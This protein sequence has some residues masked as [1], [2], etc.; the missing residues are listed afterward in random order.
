[1]KTKIIVTLGPATNTEEALRHIK[2]RGGDFVRV[3]MSHSSLSDQE[4]FMDLAR[5][6]GIPFILDTEGSQVRNGKMK[7]GLVSVAEGSEVKIYK[8]DI[9]GDATRL[10]FHPPEIFS[11]LA[12][13]DLVYIDFDAAILRISD[14]SSREEGFIVAQVISAG[15]IG[16]NKGVVMDPLHK[17]KY[18]LP[19]LSEKDLTAITMALG[20]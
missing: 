12:E 6:V 3:N 20:G 10:S 14:S 16:S 9:V 11:Q 15:D 8:D 1:M 18:Y 7:N 2:E 5:K 4:Y 19:P 13:G 17:K